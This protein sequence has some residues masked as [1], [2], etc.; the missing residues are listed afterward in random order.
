[1]NINIPNEVI[2]IILY[3]KWMQILQDKLKN[4]FNINYQ[5]FVTFLKDY[6][7]IISGYFLISCL[8]NDEYYDDLDIYHEYGQ[9]NNDEQQYINFCAAFNKVFDDDIADKL[10][11]YKTPI[12]C[13]G[14]DDIIKYRRK[15]TINDKYIDLVKT[16]Y[17][18]IKFITE[19]SNFDFLKCWFDGN[20]I[21]SFFDIRNFMLIN[22]K[23]SILE[24]GSANFEEYYDFCESYVLESTDKQDYLL[25]YDIGCDPIDFYQ[26]GMNNYTPSA[27]EM[28]NKVCNLAQYQFKHSSLINNVNLN[29]IEL[30]FIHARS[31]YVGNEKCTDY[32]IAKLLYR[33]LKYSYRGINITNVSEYFYDK[34]I[35]KCSNCGLKGRRKNWSNIYICQC[36]TKSCCQCGGKKRN[37]DPKCYLKKI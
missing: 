29:T 37:N 23:A 15:V 36:L 25:K 35:I 30:F 17:N 14:L 31:I 32:R 5:R 33:V 3:E 34:N 24:C 9:K 26:D 21:N 12:C 27:I 11:Y 22:P 28:Y 2:N 16:P 4:K 8:F 20:Q 18:P 7:A 6:N 1:M 10:D 13:Y 19:K